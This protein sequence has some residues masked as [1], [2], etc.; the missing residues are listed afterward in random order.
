MFGMAM[1]PWYGKQKTMFE[2]P[3]NFSCRFQGSTYESKVQ[4]KS[5]IP[6]KIDTQ[7]KLINLLAKNI[8]T[9]FVSEKLTNLQPGL[10]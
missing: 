6:E 9:N 8:G 4:T 10:K 1:P 3:I 7:I 5:R 2:L